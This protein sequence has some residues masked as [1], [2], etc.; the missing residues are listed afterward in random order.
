MAISCVRL[1]CTLQHRR[2]NRQRHHQHHNQSP[3]SEN[4]PRRS[5]VGSNAIGAI[6]GSQRATTIFK[7]CQ[8]TTTTI[9]TTWIT[10]VQH[11][12]SPI[13]PK[14]RPLH[15][16]TVHVAVHDPVVAVVV[17]VS[18]AIIRYWH[19]KLTSAGALVG[20]RSLTTDKSKARGRCRRL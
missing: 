1:A 18:V 15:D 9:P 16:A 14:T 12:A 19:C 13:P 5:R 8:C 4:R 3:P 2:R 7:T 17:W 20:C 10:F 6:D 11:V